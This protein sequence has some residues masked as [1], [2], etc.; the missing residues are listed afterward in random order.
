MALKSIV[1]GTSDYT[2]QEFFQSLVKNLS[3]VL[4]V[5]G[6]WVTEYLKDTQ[7]LNALA[8]WLDGKFV[9]EYRYK[10]KN[11]PCESVVNSK[12][13][14]H[15]PDKV[16]ALFPEDPDLKKLHAVSYMGVSIKDLDGE[17]M[18]HLAML[19]NKPMEEL[20]ESMAIF[21][22]FAA[23]AT[24]EMRRLKA[25]RLLEDNE[26]K[27]KRVFDGA[28]EAIIEFDANNKIVQVNA[29]G[30]KLL[31][32]DAGKV[33]GKDI[34]I[35]FDSES[36]QKLAL[37][38][39]SLS[40]KKDINNSRWIQGHLNC[41]TSSDAII[42]TEASVSRY[43]VE[44]QNYV[45]LFLHSVHE[46]V[47]TK[48]E[49]EK[50]SLETSMLKEK[51][52]FF[53]NTILGE[54]TAMQE[55]GLM[56]T[57][58]APTLTTVLI[59]GETGTGKELTAQAIHQASSRSDK[60]LITLNCAALPAELIESELFGHIRGA[61]TGAVAARDGRFVLADKGTIFLDEIGE[62][63]L[64]LQS[65]LLRV[66]QEGAFEPLGSSKTIK[67]DVR[68]IAATNRNLLEE[69]GKG[70]FREDLYYRLNVFPVHMPRLRDREKDVI[71]I[72]EA[73]LNKLSQRNKIK[74]LGLTKTDVDILLKY[75]WPGNVRELQ[76]VLERALILS[77]DGKIDLSYL[78][79]TTRPVSED[80]IID[81]KKIYS[82]QQMKNFEIQ[83]IVNALE[84]SNWK[85]SGKNG[86]AEIIGI[87]VTT[88]NSRIKKYGIVKP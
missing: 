75:H 86:A 35:F 74:F 23:R 15:I 57:Q 54:S 12:E 50:L 47:Q 34:Q 9:S 45:S 83:N 62:L 88:L 59:T 43:S 11:T 73:L 61:F 22:I 29:S 5:H 40:V 41:R 39:N 68:I 80:R 42:P 84:K 71:I 32:T 18:G 3:E 72:S 33:V 63:P 21:R 25:T 70:N 2:G 49:L 51:A 1:E 37:T 82:E 26:H 53:G 13:I 44:G 4:H 19:D 67:V 31:N 38:V 28:Q 76:N 79:K 24:A 69:V 8:F 85:I 52:N 7:E 66:I 16:I 10:V 27:L 14:C 48:N 78:V 56:I 65:K 77:K 64:A 55:V 6:V 60:P 30:L 46:Q 87:P 81:H 58:V 36:I 20:P 17:V